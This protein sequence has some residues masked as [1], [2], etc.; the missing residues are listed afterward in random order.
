MRYFIVLSVVLAGLSTACSDGADSEQVQEQE[1]ETNG[2]LYSVGGQLSGLEGIGLVVQNNGGDDLIFTENGA[3]TFGSKLADGAAWSVTVLAAPTDPSQSCE[4]IDGSGVVD[5]VDIT[6]ITIECTT[7]SFLVGGTLSGLAGKNFVL[8]NNG[9]DNRILS[10][11]GAFTFFGQITDGNTYDVSIL[12][13]PI[14]LSQSCVLENG[15]GVVDGADVSDIA[16]SCTTTTFPVAGTVSGLAG[17]GLVLQNNNGGDL[18]I[19]QDG[20][21][22]FPDALADGSLYDVSVLSMP[23]E[24]SQACVVE[25]GRGV[26]NGRGISDVEISCTTRSFSV[27]GTVS[28][29]VGS[30]LVLQNNGGDD[31]SIDQDGVFT[32]SA[33][34]LDNS[35]FSVTI[36]TESTSPAQNCELSMHTGV[37]AGSAVS[38]VSVICEQH[39]CRSLFLD[40]ALSPWAGGIS[41]ELIISTPHTALGTGLAD[42]VTATLGTISISVT[43]VVVSQ[44][45]YSSD[46]NNIFDFW[47][48]DG[49]AAGHVYLSGGSGMALEPG[50]VISFTATELSE[51]MGELQISAI[52]AL[53]V[54]P[55]AN[56]VY[57]IESNGSALTYADDGRWVHH[58]YGKIAVDNGA[59]GTSTCFDFEHT[60]GIN[61]S[62]VNFRIKNAALGMPLE[63][64]DCVEIYAPL[65]MSNTSES[66]DITNHEWYRWY[67]S[68]N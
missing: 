28:G 43:N 58:I 9:E 67:G 22:T 32:F 41:P 2:T 40:A 34:L 30:G 35:A 10:E 62:T 7:D 46:A 4:V 51:Y 61:I 65:I 68:V 12:A 60:D 29:L 39:D 19:S 48:E 66:F 24:L 59:C 26:V 38:S 44:I 18:L 52:S 50:D 55:S 42:V 16:I 13:M 54:A 37:V 25:N 49:E 57:V 15:N 14:E 6:N 36:L 63:T 33:A 5:G 3:F 64:G 45:D 47:V 21:F 11:N 53:T 56:Y 31:L 17:S 27:G 8:Q 20:V 1:P 23:V